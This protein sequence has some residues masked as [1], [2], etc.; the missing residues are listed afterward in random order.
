MAN[1]TVNSMPKSVKA[2]INP[3]LLV[4]ARKTANVSLGDAAKKAGVSVAKLEEWEAGTDAPTIA[5]LRALA[6]KY[7]RP[8]SVFYLA[9]L[10]RDFQ[11]IGDYRRLPGEVAGVLSPR[12]TFE[13]RAAQDRRE[14]AL[15]LYED[16]AEQ[17]KPFPLRATKTDD[18]EALGLRVRAFL[19][20]TI[21]TQATWK[22]PRIAYNAWRDRIENAGVL[23]FQTPPV[24][25]IP[26]KEMRG[27]AIAHDVLPIILVNAKDAYAG[28]SFT[29]M[30]ELG[31]ITLRDSAISDFSQYTADAPREPVAQRFEV[32]CNRV[33]AATLM[34]RVDFLRQPTITANTTPTWSDEQLTTLAATFGVSTDAVLRRLLTFNLTTQAFFTV[35]RAEI[36]AARKKFEEQQRKSTGGPPPHR[37]ALGHLGA[38]FARLILQNYYQQRITLNDA[39][40]YL[41][42]RLP[43]ISKLEALAYERAA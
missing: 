23:V 19:G 38:G 8:L 39:S 17:P 1:H 13:I 16:L 6:D 27:L 33:A 29:L 32:F 12:L 31:H 11:P 10:P 28:R 2:L 20:I 9:E 41:G 22:D 5:K 25:R 3:Q 35:K 30:H 34:P 24:A 42:L 14:L 36:L 43:H 15:S 7:K 40:N 37:A 4:W 21:E 18:P 26:V